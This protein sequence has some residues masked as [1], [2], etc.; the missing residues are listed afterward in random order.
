MEPSTIKGVILYTGNCSKPKFFPEKLGVILYTGSPY[1]PAYLVVPIRRLKC[2]Y[3]VSEIPMSIHYVVRSQKG[4]RE[5]MGERRG[6][7]ECSVPVIVEGE[8]HA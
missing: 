7:S 4:V 3:R 6:E 1:S 5:M 2:T 8:K